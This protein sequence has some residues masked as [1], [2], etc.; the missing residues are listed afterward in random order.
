M[1]NCPD[2][3][4]SNFQVKSS[5]PAAGFIKAVCFLTFAC[6][7][8]IFAIFLYSQTIDY[9]YLSQHL[10]EEVDGWTSRKDDRFFT[11][12]ELKNYLVLTGEV[13]LGYRIRFLFVRNYHD[14]TGRT[15]TIEIFLTDSSAEAFGIYSNYQ[16]GQPLNVGRESAYQSGRLHFWQGAAFIRMTV[17]PWTDEDEKL[18]V[19]IGR[20]SAALFP[21][22]S[23]KPSL[24]QALPKLKFIRGSSLYFHRQSSLNTRY[25]LADENLLL[26][27][28]KTEGVSGQYRLDW[29]KALLIVIRYPDEK[30]ALKAFRRFCQDVFGQDSDREATTIINNIDYGEYTGCSVQGSYLTIVFDAPDRQSAAELIQ[31][32]WRNVKRLYQKN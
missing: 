18:M 17:S 16:D 11:P 25:L 23:E 27:N 1:K 21:G 30:E 29:N 24:L 2:L 13:I 7:L 20:L 9:T 8:F 28:D 22:H 14:R 19:K 3:K 12:D 26:L 32:V 15:L 5:T 31:D 4:Q 6:S 10:P